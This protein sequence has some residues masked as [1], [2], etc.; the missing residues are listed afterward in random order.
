MIICG[1]AVCIRVKARGQKERGMSDSPYLDISAVGC[2][3]G[4]AIASFGF[5]FVEN[6]S[7]QY[8]LVSLSLIAMTSIVLVLLFYRKV[9]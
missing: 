2:S 3:F 5:T 4:F 7:L 9:R 8:I 1:I 6:P